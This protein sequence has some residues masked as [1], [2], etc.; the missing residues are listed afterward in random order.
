MPSFLAILSS[1]DF[2]LCEYHTRHKIPQHVIGLTALNRP[3]IGTSRLFINLCPLYYHCAVGSVACAVNMRQVV[4]VA[5][6]LDSSRPG[7]HSLSLA[8]AV[9]KVSF[10]VC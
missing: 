6:Q 2:R 1:V 3:K 10:R 5:I 4:A 8:E 7:T 9:K